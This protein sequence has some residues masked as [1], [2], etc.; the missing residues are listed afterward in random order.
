MMPVVVSE[1]HVSSAKEPPSGVSKLACYDVNLERT[2]SGD[3]FELRG[4]S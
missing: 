2:T 4:Q 1:A 3:G